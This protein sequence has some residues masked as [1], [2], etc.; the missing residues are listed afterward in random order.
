M[1]ASLLWRMGI[2]LMQRRRKQEQNEERFLAR[3]ARLRERR[4][5]K[6]NSSSVSAMGAAADSVTARGV[7]AGRA[8]AGFLSASGK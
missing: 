3:Q 5:K 2:H 1:F 7:D 4:H 8:V 6:S